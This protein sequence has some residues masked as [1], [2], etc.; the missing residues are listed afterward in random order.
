MKMD[1]DVK[2]VLDFWFGDAIESSEAFEVRSEV[3]FKMADDTFDDTIRD[4]FEP[5]IEP[6]FA[7]EASHHEDSAQ[8]IL[9]LILILD[10][11]PRNVYRGT[12]RA[13][14][15]DAQA[16]RLT[17]KAIDKKM[18]QTLGY[19][20]R[21]F[22]YLPLEHAEDLAPQQ[23]SVQMYETFE[24]LA[25]DDVIL[26]NNAKEAVEYAQ[27]HRDIIAEFGRFPHRNA[28]V[29]RESTPAEIAYLNSGAENFGQSADPS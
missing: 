17:R 9:A 13:F 2:K 14:A 29:N 8:G 23:L 15:Y 28:I 4:L 10:Q 20:Q 22:L 18:D 24:S 5:Y 27:L 25:G 19:A 11:F 21:L 7:G 16:L 1:I 26:Q 6:V 3:W 12:A